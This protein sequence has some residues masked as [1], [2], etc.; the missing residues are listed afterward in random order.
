MQVYQSRLKAAITDFLRYKADPTGYKPSTPAVS[1][2]NTNRSPSKSKGRGAQEMRDA[3]DDVASTPVAAPGTLTFSVPIRQGIT[4]TLTLAGIP[5]DF[6][7]DE[8][9]RASKVAS[10]LLETMLAAS[11]A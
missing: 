10:T 5:N 4:A 1:R 8:A 2:S 11:A 3:D 6:T 7:A 9:T